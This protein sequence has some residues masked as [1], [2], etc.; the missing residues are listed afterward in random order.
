MITIVGLG[1]GGFGQITVEGLEALRSGRKVLLRTAVHPSVAALQK[2]GVTC[3]SCDDLYEA[4]NSFDQVYRAIAERVLA[5]DDVVFAV[6]GHPM[7]G[8]RSVQLIQAGAP[9][10]V[11]I[12]VG[13]SFLDS[14]LLTLQ[15]DPVDGLELLDALQLERRLPSGDLPAII[16]QVHSRSV[17]SDT[18]LALMERYPDDHPV[19]LVRAAGV[20]GQEQAARVR[21]HELDHLEW[22]DYLTTLY[23]P[24]L[25][26][27]R[28][29]ES[30]PRRWVGS[31]W[32]ADPLV[33]VMA[34]LRGRQGCPWD[35]EQ[36]HKT[37]RKYMLEEA[38]EAVEAIDSGD[39]DKLCEELGDVLLQVVF[40]AQ[41]AREAGTFDFHDIVQV[42]TDKLIR[43]HPHVF[44]AVEA[45]TPED[46]TRNWEAI[47]RTERGEQKRP[48][49]L[50]QGVS[51]AMP[52]LSRAA[53]VQRRTAK[54]GFEWDDLDGPVQKVRE[55]L[56][57][58]LT[59]SPEHR[60]DEAGD[61]LFAV[62]NLVRMMKLDPEVALTATSAKFIRRFQHI[63]RR[64]AE[65][66]LELT[67]MSLQE[68]DNLWV[69]A[70]LA[71]RTKNTGKNN[72]GA[73]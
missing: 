58:L 47:K 65:M 21:L 5:H 71:E 22:A 57:E 54:V 70:K 56:E 69:E 66:G 25:P 39:S 62:V 15:V 46:V 14:L 68:M 18:K 23:L 38:Y 40:H 1:P 34:T 31:H 37:L 2:W 35:R 8:E 50:L 13:P 36:T 42:I 27:S 41:M 43:R 49:S 30:D 6:P 4:G 11:E 16:M 12:L 10:R 63:E 64:A 53:E 67:K 29:G 26:R 60:E 32:P 72:Q 17:A 59:A 9:D 45:T 44:G 73:G 33:E 7:V 19:T 24:P 20:S 28:V 3:A 48:D 52:A 51:T 55:E 61:L